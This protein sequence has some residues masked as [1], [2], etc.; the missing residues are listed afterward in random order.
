MAQLRTRGADLV[1][2]NGRRVRL[3]GVN[4]FGF[5][6]G[7]TMVGAARAWPSAR[8]KLSLE[9]SPT[10]L[11][12]CL[13]GCS[14]ITWSTHGGRCAQTLAPLYEEWANPRWGVLL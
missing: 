4:W 13:I 8:L 3:H 1:D 7:T 10:N 14:P 5:N 9:G 12:D 2:G 6:S 11:T